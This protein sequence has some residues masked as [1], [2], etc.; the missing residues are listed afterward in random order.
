LITD[1]LF[2][3][4][5]PCDFPP[6]PCPS[7]FFASSATPPFSNPSI[8][9]RHKLYVLPFCWQTPPSGAF[10]TPP[11]VPFFR[12]SPAYIRVFARVANRAVFCARFALLT[13]GPVLYF[14]FVL[15]LLPT[16]IFYLNAPFPFSDL[17]F[18][19]PLF[20]SL[21]IF[22]FGPPVFLFSSQ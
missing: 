4:G 11:S 9:F 6:C 18:R 8:P 20:V 5:F 1:S 12:V 3:S 13:L 10:P 2:Y 14:S 7:F 15:C 16:I 22:L 21:L 17:I 19:T